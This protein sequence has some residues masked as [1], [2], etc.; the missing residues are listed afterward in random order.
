[1][2]ARPISRTSLASL[3]RLGAPYQPSLA[4]APTDWTIAHQLLQ[5]QHLLQQQ[6]QL[7]SI[8]PYD[9]N[10]DDQNNI[11]IANSQGTNGNL[12]Q[13]S[14]SG[15]PMSCV[16]LS[17]GSNGG[18]VIDSSGNVW[19]ATTASNNIYRYSTGQG[20]YGLPQGIVTFPTSTPPLGITADG[21][22]NVYFTSSRPDRS[23]R[24]LV[25]RRRPLR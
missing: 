9:I 24:F 15:A 19:F 20:S 6:R 18:G 23:T 8:K 5:L 25:P 21:Q 7:S 3:L 12:S 4:S 17:G 2:A 14:N 11:W 10:V 1:M 16:F 13:I 22:G